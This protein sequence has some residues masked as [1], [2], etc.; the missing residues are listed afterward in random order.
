MLDFVRC[1]VWARGE[2]QRKR[3]HGRASA[4]YNYRNGALSCYYYFTK[5][6]THC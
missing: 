3:L 5:S 2:H 1:E 4:G 6:T